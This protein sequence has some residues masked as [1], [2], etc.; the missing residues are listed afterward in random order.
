MN[1]DQTKEK[2]KDKIPANFENIAMHEFGKYDKNSNGCIEGAEL[3]PLLK[4]MAVFFGFDSNEVESNESIRKS[5]LSEIDNDN[6]KKITFK[7]FKFYFLMV[8]SKQHFID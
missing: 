5:L 7:E 3:I 1:Y 2:L 4:D 6:D 8:Y